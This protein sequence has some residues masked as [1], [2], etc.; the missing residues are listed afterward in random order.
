MVSHYAAFVWTLPLTRISFTPEA[1][2]RTTF[3]WP[4]L[5]YGTTPALT[6][7]VAESLLGLFESRYFQHFAAY[8]TLTAWTMIHFDFFTTS[9]TVLTAS[10]I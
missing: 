2:E 5:V 6:H 7:I 4:V 1:L 3:I 10:I 8:C 9:L